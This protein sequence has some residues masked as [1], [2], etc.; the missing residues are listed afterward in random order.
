MTLEDES[1]EIKLAVELIMLLENNGIAPEL[2]LAALDIVKNDYLNKI[3]KQT[4]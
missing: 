4:E 1:P 3:G 2:V